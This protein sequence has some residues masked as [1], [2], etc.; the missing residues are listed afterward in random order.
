MLA[1]PSDI[2]TS[3]RHP[4]RK[5][6]PATKCASTLK[7]LVG[8][9]E[10]AEEQEVLRKPLKDLGL[11]LPGKDPDTAHIGLDELK[12]LIR[13]WKLHEKGGGGFWRDQDA[14]SL[15]HILINHIRQQ[16]LYRDQ[17]PAL[18]APSVLPQTTTPSAGVSPL[19]RHQQQNV[20]RENRRTS[21]IDRILRPYNGDLFS[22]LWETTDGIALMSRYSQPERTAAEIGGQ[23]R[24]RARRKSRWQEAQMLGTTMEQEQK[25][26]VARTSSVSFVDRGRQRTMDSYS[27]SRTLTG[28]SSGARSSMSQDDHCSTDDDSD[29][30]AADEVKEAEIL[31]MA[32][33]VVRQLYSYSCAKGSEVAMVGEGALDVVSAMAHLPCPQVVAHASAALSNIACNAEA[34]A[35]MLT[36]ET[37][38]KCIAPLIDSEYSSR[39]S[40]LHAAQALYKLTL[41][42]N[43]ELNVQ[44]E[45]MSAL[46]SMCGIEDGDETRQVVASSLINILVGPLLV[47][48]QKV[49]ILELVSPILSMLCVAPSPDSNN[50]LC[51]ASAALEVSRIE[52]VRKESIETG[53]VSVVAA[54]LRLK[55][56]SDIVALTALALRNLTATT[57][58]LPAI[59]DAHALSVMPLLAVHENP[60]VRTCAADIGR[61]L[62]QSTAL[63][64]RLERAGMISILIRLT[65]TP[66]ARP[67]AVLALSSMTLGAEGLLRRL[68]REG[69]HRILIETAQG[70][71]IAVEA[72]ASGLC[73]LLSLPD[74]CDA[75]LS[76]GLLR[77]LTCSAGSTRIDAQRA[78]ALMAHNLACL[79]DQSMDKMLQTDEIVLAVVHLAESKDDAEVRRQAIKSLSCLS[80]DP[81]V[82]FLL[83]KEQGLF[84]SLLYFKTEYAMHQTL[85]ALLSNM[86]CSPTLHKHMH[87]G[88]CMSL[89]LEICRGAVAPP[90]SIATSNNHKKGGGG[91]GASAALGCAMTLSNFA[92]HSSDAVADDII[93]GIRELIRCTDTTD[94]HE[95]RLRCCQALMYLSANPNHV[96]KVTVH[97]H[98]GIFL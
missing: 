87:E 30:D 85:A 74:N 16:G 34:R 33:K 2:L 58:C 71:T 26:V 47:H 88:G 15:A 10:R 78:A 13:H 75:L 42:D 81:R 92:Q 61:N 97:M 82:C 9:L 49:R 95:V 45:G 48:Q 31:D 25:G 11:F 23:A 43:S 41:E 66:T 98:F 35:F 51:V 93:T 14:E 70:G 8:Q 73:N 19:R 67:A 96:T 86:S 17:R 29:V 18:T 1:S 36:H 4:Q 94:S 90:T 72:A 68:V 40:R 6:R 44:A 77:A 24:R 12:R 79:K 38:R 5:L 64:P 27:R 54:Q 60:S 56:A 3:P 59:L 21:Y 53:I 62:T 63:L 46:S 69:G 7:K 76:S 52:S 50:A 65:E 20:R 28:D 37:I 55:P 32:R 80:T 39:Q 57:E 22:T 83:A 84:T 89:L 91:G